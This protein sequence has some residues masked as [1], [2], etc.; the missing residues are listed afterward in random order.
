M[1]EVRPAPGRH[2]RRLRGRRLLA[3]AGHR[4]DRRLRPRPRARPVPAPGELQVY[5]AASLKKALDEGRRRLAGRQPRLDARRVH[6]LVRRPRDQDRA[7]RPGR[8]A[9]CRRTPPNPQKLVDAGLASGDAD[10]V[11]R[12]PAHRHRARRTTRPAS[13]PRRTSPS[14]GVKVIAAGPEVPITKYATQLV[15]NLARSRAIP[16][17][18]AAAYAANVVS[19]EDNVAGV[20]AQGRAR[21]GR[22]GHRLRDRR[23]GSDKVKTVDVPAR[24]TCPRPTAASS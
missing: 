23:M 9:S 1:D 21:R 3:A 19:Q 4:A 16:A 13:P 24:R 20:R 6:R 11:R 2:G 17:D 18:F 14:P 12:Q 10:A 22:R 7:G 8:R 15:A 5:A